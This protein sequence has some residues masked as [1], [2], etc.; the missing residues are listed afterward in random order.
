MLF[1]SATEGVMVGDGAPDVGAARAAGM[2]MI[3]VG[4]GISTPVGPDVQAED[5]AA[6]E[7]ALRG[8]GV[9]LG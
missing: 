6:L 1:R 5:V 3:G 7:G 2:P 4:W 9:P 8:L